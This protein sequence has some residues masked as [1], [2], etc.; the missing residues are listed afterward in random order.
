MPT[1]PTTLKPR[2]ALPPLGAAWRA[3]MRS[4]RIASL[5]YRVHETEQWLAACASDGILDGVC[6]RYIRADLEAL[7][8][9]LC[10]LEAQQRQWRAH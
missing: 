6:L 5:Y 10:V 2:L 1:A 9:Q 8:V 4:L 3:V 7:R